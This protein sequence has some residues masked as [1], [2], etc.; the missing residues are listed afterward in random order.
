MRSVLDFLGLHPVFYSLMMAGLLGL[1]I[2]AMIKWFHHTV[3]PA[4]GEGRDAAGP[5]LPGKDELPMVPGELY[6]PSGGSEGARGCTRSGRG[7]ASQAGPGGDGTG[8]GGERMTTLVV[9]AVLEVVIL[10]L[11]LRR[12]F[13][14]GRL[15]RVYRRYRRLQGQRER[16]AETT[17]QL[18]T[19][20]RYKAL[21]ARRS[22]EQ[23]GP[24]I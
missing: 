14:K 18:A 7:G 3:A 22:W 20:L 15:R 11:I 5:K 9:I 24:G 17:K 6:A 23:T 21:K 1:T 4:F 13:Q 12:G 2:E 16:D 10:A 19:F 8:E